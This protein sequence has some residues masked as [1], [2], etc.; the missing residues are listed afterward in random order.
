MATENIIA[1]TEMILVQNHL[2]T[3]YLFKNDG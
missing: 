1:R 3:T 2:E